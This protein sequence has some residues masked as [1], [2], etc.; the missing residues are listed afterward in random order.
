MI[1]EPRLMTSKDLSAVFGLY[2]K[3]FADYLISTKY[4]QAELQ[5]VLMPDNGVVFTFIVY[6]KDE[7]EITDFI[8]FYLTELQVPKSEEHDHTTL[9]VATLF[10]SSG[11]TQFNKL[12]DLV[13]FALVYAKENLN[14]DLFRTTF[15][16]EHGQ[17]IRDLRFKDYLQE[18]HYYT[19][20]NYMLHNQVGPP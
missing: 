2:K 3:K 13:K 15:H 8:S 5:Q 14:C 16:G 19:Y 10:Y 7:K 4:S 9:K 1:G 20:F 6:N 12:S 11:S 17:F 18:H